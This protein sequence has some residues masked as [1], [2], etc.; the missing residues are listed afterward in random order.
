MLPGPSKLALRL[1]C[2]QLKWE[3]DNLLGLKVEL[4]VKDLS[5]LN[6]ENFEW[7]KQS[8]IRRLTISNDFFG[9]HCVHSASACTSFLEN[10]KF[11]NLSRLSLSHLNIKYEGELISILIAVSS[12]NSLNELSLDFVLY[13]EEDNSINSASTAMESHY[14]FPNLTA[15]NLNYNVVGYNYNYD[16]DGSADSTNANHECS[17]MKCFHQMCCPQLKSL[18][19]SLWQ[20]GCNPRAHFLIW[21]LELLE[22]VSSSLNY[23]KI[24][25][26]SLQ[27]YHNRHE[28]ETNTATDERA[29]NIGSRF[30]NLKEL[31]VDLSSALCDENDHLISTL[32]SG[33]MHLFHGMRIYLEKLTV[34]FRESR[35]CELYRQYELFAKNSH[36]NLK[37]L[38]VVWNHFPLDWKLITE[39]SDQLITLE[40]RPHGGF[41]N[42]VKNFEHIPLSLK[43]IVLFEVGRTVGDWAFVKKL[44]STRESLIVQ[45][46]ELI[47]IKKATYMG[48]FLTKPNFIWKQIK[49]KNKREW[50][51]A[52]ALCDK[53]DIP[54]GKLH[55]NEYY[56]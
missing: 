40:M 53:F 51:A 38:S 36:P 25:V 2:K 15:F 39:L 33:W 54:L 23:L 45:Y 42:G 5:E 55:R 43:K 37:Y 24:K 32:V 10:A 18:S 1:S 27:S 14:N 19:V 9:N 21:Y 13:I 12:I 49:Y 50:R 31:D 46:D 20:E 7:I 6:C 35:T 28:R 47:N 26:V 52:F 34:N 41:N 29:V 3:I 44:I 17:Y 8:L 11:I 30:K 16:S 4:P 22:K 48:V 56:C